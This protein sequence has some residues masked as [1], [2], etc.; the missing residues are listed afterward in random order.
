[1]KARIYP[2][3]NKATRDAV[4]AEARKQCAEVHKEYQ[5]ALDVLIAYTLREQLGFGHDRIR[6]FFLAMVKNQVSI[7]RAYAGESTDDNEMPEFVMEYKLKQCGVDVES[8]LSDIETYNA[9][10]LLNKEG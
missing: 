8:I 2:K 10:L 6:K 1:M 9:E 3:V 4:L 5:R 7:R